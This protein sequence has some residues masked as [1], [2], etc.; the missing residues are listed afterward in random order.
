MPFALTGVKGQS[1]QGLGE[2]VEYGSESEKLIFHIVDKF[3]EIPNGL[4]NGLDGF[5]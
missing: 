5:G 4:E 3:Q 1:S 2:F